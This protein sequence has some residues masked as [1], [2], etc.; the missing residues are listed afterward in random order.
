V[1]DGIARAETL[2][3]VAEGCQTD[4][5][6]VYFRRRSPCGDLACEW[7]TSTPL[8]V[9]HGP[10][11]SERIAS[12]VAEL[13]AASAELGCEP[14]GDCIGDSEDLY[15]LACNANTCVMAIAPVPNPCSLASYDL[16]TPMDGERMD[17]G[18]VDLTDE[19]QAQDLRID[20]YDCLR[21]AHTACAP[22]VLTVVSA[23]EQGD[24]IVTETT[25]TPTADN[26]VCSRDLFVDSREERPGAAQRNP[27]SGQHAPCALRSQA[28]SGASAPSAQRYAMGLPGLSTWQS[29]L[30]VGLAKQMAS[31]QQ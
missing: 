1:L 24:S 2:S 15:E 21:Q 18:V 16:E 13:C 22:A 29:T 14:P 27:Y 11:V 10:E 17:C 25:I 5:D 4:A 23:T 12:D 20:A 28:G 19:G 7:Q 3:G 9:V 8:A 6:C 30:S 31:L 26:G